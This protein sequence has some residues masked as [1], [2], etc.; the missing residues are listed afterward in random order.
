MQ[1]SSIATTKADQSD[2]VPA[3]AKRAAAYRLHALYF[4]GNCDARHGMRCLKP[5]HQLGKIGGSHF[6]SWIDLGETDH[7]IAK[8]GKRRFLTN[9]VC[10]DDK[11]S[12]CQDSSDRGYQEGPDPHQVRALKFADSNLS[13]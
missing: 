5:S 13:F 1:Q 12:D 9:E 8:V 2:I 3:K 10:P 6:Q 4:L 11:K 7:F